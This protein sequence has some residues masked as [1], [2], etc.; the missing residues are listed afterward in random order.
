MYNTL[1][2]EKLKEIAN[3]IQVFIHELLKIINYEVYQKIL[4]T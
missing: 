1:V 2:K 4:V 3:Q